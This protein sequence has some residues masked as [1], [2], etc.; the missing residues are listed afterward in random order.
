MHN[1]RSESRNEGEVLD[2]GESSEVEMQESIDFALVQMKAGT[3]TKIDTAL[4]RLGHITT[5]SVSIAAVTSARR[6]SV[7]CHSRCA[8]RVARRFTRWTGNIR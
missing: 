5:G 6:A 3:F 2:T 7:P 8:A 4:R 1:A